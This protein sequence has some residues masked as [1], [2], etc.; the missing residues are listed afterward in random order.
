MSDERLRQ[1]ERTWRETGAVEDEAAWLRERVRVGDLDLEGLEL[2]AYC[3]RPAARMII[4]DSSS[5]P[6]REPLEIQAWVEGVVARSKPAAVIA[7]VAAAEKFLPRW[8]AACP[9]D[10]RPRDAL[11][12]VRAWARTPRNDEASLARLQLALDEADRAAEDA[13]LVDPALET[14]ALAAY[15]AARAAHWGAMTIPRPDLLCR[16]VVW[17]ARLVSPFRRGNVALIQGRMA[18]AVTAWVLR[19]PLKGDRSGAV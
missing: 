16:D 7:A 18:Q 17:V 15:G 10:T 3:G 4:D 14:I 5:K 6:P 9:D 13:K 12:A 8:L 19:A 1:L 11:Q 2:A